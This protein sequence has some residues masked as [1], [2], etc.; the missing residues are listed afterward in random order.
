MVLKNRHFPLSPVLIGFALDEV[1]VNRKNVLHKEK[2]WQ[3]V[4]QIRY[5]FDI[6]R[7]FFITPFLSIPPIIDNEMA[8]GENPL[9]CWKNFVIYD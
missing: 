5:R 3:F 7:T 2:L 6:V 8:S 9:F 1:F 4:T